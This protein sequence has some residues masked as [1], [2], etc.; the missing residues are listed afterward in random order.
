[1]DLPFFKKGM[2][3]NGKCRGVK[4]IKQYTHII[5]YT[6]M[7]ETL[8]IC[9]DINPRD[10][11]FDSEEE[12]QTLFCLFFRCDQAGLFIGMDDNDFDIYDETNVKRGMDWILEKTAN[13]AEWKALYLKLSRVFATEDL[14]IGLCLALSYDYLHLF[15]A[16]FWTW[17]FKKDA[18][19]ETA[20]QRFLLIL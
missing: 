5:L 16:A 7:S 6:K 19:Y 3:Y 11:H 12:Y 13:S 20:M 1:L 17:W 15:Y 8:P 14:D 4:Y 9:L 10:F 2:R 18:E